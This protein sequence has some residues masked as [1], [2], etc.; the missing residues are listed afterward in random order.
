MK[1]KRRDGIPLRISILLAVVMAVIFVPL[2]AGQGNAVRADASNVTILRYTKIESYPTPAQAIGMIGNDIYVA[3]RTNSTSHGGDTSASMVVYVSHDKGNTWQQLDTYDFSG[4]DEMRTGS[5]MYL[6]PVTGNL[7]LI[8][9][10]YNGSSRRGGAIF[11]VNSTGAHYIKTIDDGA[12]VEPLFAPIKIGDTWYLYVYIENDISSPEI[13]KISRLNLENYSEEQVGDYESTLA[14][15]ADRPNEASAVLDGSTLYLFI[16]FEGSSPPDTRH[17]TLWTADWNSTGNITNVQYISTLADKGAGSPTSALLIPNTHIAYLIHYTYETTNTFRTNLMRIDLNNR[18]ILSDTNITLAGDTSDEVGNGGIWLVDP[19][20]ENNSGHYV[21][22]AAYEN[23]NEGG[24]GTRDGKF[25]AALSV[26]ELVSQ[27][28][29]QITSPSNNATINASSVTVRWSGS[30]S[31]NHYEIQLDNGAWTNV[32]TN[33]SYTFS[34]L[35]D[36]QHTVVVRAYDSS[37]NYASDSVNFTVSTS[38]NNS[39]TGGA[40]WT[41]W[42]SIQGHYLEIGLI[43]LLIII[44]VAAVSKR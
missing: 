10:L 25:F 28:S 20:I 38:S 2:L 13:W 30:G 41:V 27:I 6:N 44:A 24:N 40:G 32:G 14:A 22:Y 8:S 11:E 1:S 26:P 37:G 15:H 17:I 12:Y 21:I 39:T 35:A 19:S 16:R 36:G 23:G 18:T 4:L 29:V 34:G 43:V 5:T 33:T 42:D 3:M 9:S 7:I 31:I